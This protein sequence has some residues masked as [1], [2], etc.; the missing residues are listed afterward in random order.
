MKLAVKD[1]ISAQWS[2]PTEFFRSVQLQISMAFTYPAFMNQED[3][4]TV[5]FKSSTEGRSAEDVHCSVQIKRYH[6]SLFR[7]IKNQ[8]S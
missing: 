1:A 7:N 4:Q 2:V 8:T 6:G 3:V 5:V